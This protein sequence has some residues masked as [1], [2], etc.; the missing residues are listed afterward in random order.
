MTHIIEFL[1]HVQ[2]GMN[3][4][5]DPRMWP[6]CIRT[7]L[8]LESLKNKLEELGFSLNYPFQHYKDQSLSGHIF[9][10]DGHQLHLRAYPLKSGGFGLK[11]HYEWSAETN[12]I[13]HLACK[14][15]SY[16][17]GCRMIRK[18]W[19]IPADNA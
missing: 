6:F 15:I 12:P 13:R 19:G 18:L 7:E 11:A 8:D 2:R 1:D 10:D 14:D 16:P 5:A 17:R 9:Y 4:E 3:P